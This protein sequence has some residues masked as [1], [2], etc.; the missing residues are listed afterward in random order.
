[1]RKKYVVILEDGRKSFDTK[2]EAKKYSKNIK[3]AK[4]RI[5]K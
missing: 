1:M 2:Q 3:G 5:S 4:I